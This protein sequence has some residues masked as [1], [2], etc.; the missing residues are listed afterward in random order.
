M[1]WSLWLWIVPHIIRE[2]MCFVTLACPRKEAPSALL[3]RVEISGF[4]L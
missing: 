4:I 3:S 1:V 2:K